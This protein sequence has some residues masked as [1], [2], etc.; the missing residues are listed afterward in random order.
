MIVAYA[1][2][3]RRVPLAKLGRGAA[4]RPLAHVR[5][6]GGHAVVERASPPTPEP[7][8]LLRY[9]RVLRRIA[10]TSAAVLPFRFGTVTTSDAS[11]RAAIEP[12]GQEALA[13]AFERVRDAVQI[14]LRVT[15]EASP[16]AV[17]E[18]GG[19]GTRWIAARRAAR[20]VP[21]IAP[22][23]DATAPFVRASHAERGPDAA[24][25]ATV[26]HL[27]ER[28]RLAAWKRAFAEGRAALHA[29]VRVVASGP[30]P[31][32]AFAELG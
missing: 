8:T 18:E 12:F 1:L 13:R 19:P 10:R 25:L 4:G 14:T 11:L 31:A 6:A 7:A 17:P 16:V 23:T 27:V 32:Y 5:V 29:R 3:P 15:G 30:W 22:V 28:R 20:S 9:D 26:Y 21:E 24:R 2:V